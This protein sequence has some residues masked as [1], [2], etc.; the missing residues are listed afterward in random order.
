MPWIFQN[1]LM[2]HFYAQYRWTGEEEEGEGQGK[3]NGVLVV[4]EIGNWE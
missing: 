4:M 1:N 3:V 2:L